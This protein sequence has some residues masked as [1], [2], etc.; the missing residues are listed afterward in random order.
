MDKNNSDYI[1][2][3]FIINSF[4]YDNGNKETSGAW[5][6]FPTTKENVSALFKEIGLPNNADNNKYFI[7]SYHSGNNDIAKFLSMYT[8]IDELNYLASRI[9]ELD[10]IEMS[11]FQTAIQTEKISTIANAINVTYNTEYYNVVPDMYSLSDVGEYAAETEG[12]DISKIGELS[13]YIDYEA[14]GRDYAR[15]NCGEFLGEVYLET[16]CTEWKDIYSGELEDIAPEYIVTEYGENVQYDYNFEMQF[17]ASKDLAADIDSYIRSI[18]SCY[19]EKYPDEFEQMKY[20]SDCLLERRTL[21]VKN[22]LT[23]ADIQEGSSLVDKIRAF[24]QQYPCDKYMLY[25]VKDGEQTRDYRYAPYSLLQKLGLNVDKSNYELTYTCGL[26]DDT[27]LESL[28]TKFNT[29]RP[30]DFKGRS[31]SVS[32]IVVLHRN[33]KD[34]AYYCDSAGFVEV[35]EFFKENHLETAEKSTEQNYNQIDE[36]INNEPPEKDTITVLVVEPMQ[37]PYTKEIP[38]GLEALQ[39]EVGGLID[40]T[41]PFAEPATLICNDEGKI[42]RME[43]NRALYDAEGEIYDIVA[44]PFVIAGISGESITGL[45]DEQIKRF[46]KHFQQPEVFVKINDKI[47]AIPTKPSIKAKLNR[48]QKEKDGRDKTQPQKPSLKQEL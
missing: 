35:P 33:G 13:D 1:F 31:M 25:Q 19:A 8:N 39:K 37:E 7:D 32:D 46:L 18:D 6:Y 24:E 12:Y 48:L 15:R 21:S 26:S 23:A 3:A 47:A 17:E 22:M 44:G 27:T 11:V 34:K 20:F 38:K 5:L 45:D 16:G 40:I 4:E 28:F 10:D 2:K 36:Q 30:Q 9:S 43:L 29:D 14:Y 41:Y 42:N